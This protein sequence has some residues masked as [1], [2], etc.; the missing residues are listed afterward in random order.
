MVPDV[1][2]GD[3]MRMVCLNCARRIVAPR[4]V[5]KYAGLGSYLK[6]RGSFTDTVKL[7]FARIDGILG[8]NLPMDAYKGETCW[9]NSANR[10]HTKAW[11]DAGW[12]V[13]RIDL[14]EGYVVFKKVRDVPISASRSKI[15]KQFTPVHVRRPKPRTPSKTQ[16]SKLYAR[17]KNLERQRTAIPSFHGSFK[18]KSKHEKTLYKPDEKPKQ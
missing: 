5:S 18:P 13:Q 7:G 11:L 8:D 9:D 2:T 3:P 4:T 15:N 10:M 14:K 6:F 17:I 12:E 1:A 16:L